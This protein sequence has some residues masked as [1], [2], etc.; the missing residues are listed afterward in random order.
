MTYRMSS[1]KKEAGTFPGKCQPPFWVWA[2]VLLLVVAAFARPADAADSILYRLFLRDGTSIVSYGEFARVADRVV[3]SIPVGE[4]AATPNL[5]LISIPDNSVDWDRTD[6]YSDAVR[7]KRYGETRGESD[8]AMLSARVTEALNQISLTSDP[9][10]RLSMAVEAR[11]NLA[12]WPSQ[13]FGYRAADVSQLVGMLD[14]VISELRVAAGQSSFD[15]SLVANV[16]VAPPEELLPTPGFRETMEQALAAAAA[17]PEPTER[18]SLLDAVASALREPAR[19]GGWA[20]ALRLRAS[21]DLATE[22]RINKSYTD[23]STWALA[24]A[25]ARASKG[26][27]AGVQ[28][29]VQSV[30]KADDR[31]GRRRPQETTALLQVLDLRL[32]AA[33]RTR[34]AHDAWIIRLD[35]FKSYRSAIASALGEMRASTV[36]L[37]NIR[38]LAGPEPRLLPRLEQRFVMARQQLVAITPPVELQP[39]HALYISAFQ[40]AKRAASSRRTAVLSGDM[41][42]AW[43]ASSAAA[44]ALLMFQNAGDEL[45]RLT[46]PPSNR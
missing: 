12:R 17:T 34:L 32:D 41:S 9:A 15:V 23:L 6:R 31:L 8:F 33:R 26:D 24:S 4:P 10:R 36:L 20:A 16:S 28:T 21:S 11:G 27:V 44:G 42:L 40:M 1:S 35:S 7:A 14:E 22:L 25:T 13:N 39:V 45:D 43:E 29:L 19:A 37:E 18:I 38:Q 5:Q 46:T 30:L 3:L 2:A